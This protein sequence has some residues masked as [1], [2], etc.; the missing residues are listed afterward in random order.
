V[1]GVSHNDAIRAGSN[2]WKIELSIPIG[3][4]VRDCLAASGSRTQFHICL[5]NWRPTTIFNDD[6]LKECGWLLRQSPAMNNAK[7]WQDDQCRTPRHFAAF[8]VEIRL[9]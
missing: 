9:I 3:L 4:S 7:N 2:I 1:A 5:R 8:P 6:A